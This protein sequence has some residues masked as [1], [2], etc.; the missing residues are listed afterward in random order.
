MQLSI[1]AKG[2]RLTHIAHHRI[3]AVTAFRI[4]KVLN[5]VPGF[6]IHGAHKVIKSRIHTD[7][8]G[9]RR[10]FNNCSSNQKPTGLTHQ[11]LARLKNQPQRTTITFAKRTEAIGEHPSQVLNFRFHV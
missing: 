1:A 5:F 8:Q 3:N 2:I 10:G 9:G 4:G 6:V 7:K 11:K